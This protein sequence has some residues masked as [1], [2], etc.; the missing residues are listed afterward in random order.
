MTQHITLKEVEAACRTAYK[1]NR[2]IAQGPTSIDYGYQVLGEDKVVRVCAI[3]AALTDE[4]LEVISTKKLQQVPIG[5]IIRE[6][7]SL[8]SWDAD[9][10]QEL[11]H[12]QQCHDRWLDDMRNG[13][14]RVEHTKSVFKQVIGL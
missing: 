7:E 9:D 1:E 8:I 13:N 3:G 11:V 10:F 12:I 6:T 5:A 4:T 14:Q 2:L